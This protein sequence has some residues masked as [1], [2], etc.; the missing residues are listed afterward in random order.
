MAKSPEK[1]TAAPTA[2]TPNA[3]SSA[4]STP[5]IAR[6]MSAVEGPPHEFTRTALATKTEPVASGFMSPPQGN[7]A[8]RRLRIDGAPRGEV[9]LNAAMKVLLDPV[10]RG[11]ASRVYSGQARNWSR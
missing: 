5:A 7:G 6:E 9:R 1:T 2:N 8:P 11:S 4:S 3:E 10:A